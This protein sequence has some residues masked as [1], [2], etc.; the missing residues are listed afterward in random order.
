MKNF[1]NKLSFLIAIL[2][3]VVV[4]SIFQSCEK[5]ED[6]II[7]AV[8]ETNA[9][10][11]DN[12]WKLTSF[13]LITANEDIPPPLLFTPSDIK[14]PAG[15]YDL[16][17]MVLDA[18]D[19][20]N[21]IVNFTS[22]REIR[23]RGAEIDLLNETGIGSYFVLNDRRIR[24]KSE[25][26]LVYHYIYNENSK[27]ISFIATEEDA[28]RLINKTNQKLIDAVIKSTPSGI[29]DFL[30][31]LLFNNE[32]LQGLINDVVVDAISGKLDFIYDLDPEE[33]SELLAALIF[34]ELRSIDWEN[35]IYEA[36]LG[37]LEEIS[38]IDQEAVANLIAQEVA[39]F[40][41][42][43]F[44]TESIYNTIFPYI[45]EIPANS[46]YISESIAT[47]VSNIFLEIFTEANL[48]PIISSAWQSF[49]E[50]SPDQV[51]VIADTLTGIV[52]EIYLNEE[53]LSNIV[54][55]FTQLIDNTPVFQL[56][57]LAAQTTQEIENLVNIINSAFPE[58][59]LD[60]DYESMENSIRLAYIAIK[61]VITII[62]PEAAANQIAELLLNEFLTESLVQSLFVSAI[63]YLQNID[64]ETAGIVI[65]QWLLGFQNEISEGLYN[66]VRD[67]LSPILDNLD[68][69][70]TS[71]LIAE[72]VR[73]FVIQNFN[74]EN[75]FQLI[76]PI[77]DQLVNL[78][79]EEVA[80]YLAKLIINLDI[81]EDTITEEAIAGILSPV[82]ESIQ[83]LEAETIS[84]AI[85][86]AL[87]ASNIFQD[88]ITEERISLVIS[89]LIY[90][91]YWQNVR[92]ANNFEEITIVL[93]H[94]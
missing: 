81:I 48:Q 86:N 17:D 87:V 47:L 4:P 37:Q 45:N 49:V 90:N 67:F 51:S 24:L 70:G 18:S 22:E 84:Q 35:F 20:A 33:T 50:L 6:D 73:N 64:A 85:V 52:Q 63:E 78:S 38:N 89:L 16:D 93:R 44:T 72:A 88:N 26:S 32:A 71:L 40:I 36:I 83:E 19:M 42:E 60:P 74:Q 27:E 2:L 46:E 41:D 57:Q 75:I 54:L 1:I 91:S 82:L 21:Y 76:L 59:E 79:A 25:Q 10:L 30:A 61:P 3:L 58:L 43:N 66:F 13:E 55:P 56:G 15:I 12:E 65:T 9:I 14:I 23:T 77:I 39:A 28:R 34:E 11:I 68:P 69:E 53:N 80:A 62:G 29:G 92:I 31:E 8:R 94:E 5:P 7:R